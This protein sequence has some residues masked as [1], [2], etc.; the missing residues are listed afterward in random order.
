MAG[1]SARAWRLSVKHAYKGHIRKVMHLPIQGVRSDPILKKSCS[2]SLPCGNERAFAPAH[3]Q[4]VFAA[5]VVHIG[6]AGPVVVAECL[7][8]RLGGEKTFP[9]DLLSGSS[10]PFQC[11]PDFVGGILQLDLVPD[12]SPTEGHPHSSF[13]FQTEHRWN[14]DM[15]SESSKRGYYSTVTDGYTVSQPQPYL[16]L[17]A[18]QRR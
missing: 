2:P 16:N 10:Q 7:E 6:L 15:R 17:K 13:C 1:W 12:F 8:K 14:L 18:R 5:L 3:E 11:C 4:D 9:E